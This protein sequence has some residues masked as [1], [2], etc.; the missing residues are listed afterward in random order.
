[1][2]N[3]GWGNKLV[4]SNKGWGNK[5]EV[6]L[7]V[8]IKRC[9]VTDKWKDAITPTFA[10]CAGSE[11]K[12]QEGRMVGGR[13]YG[14]KNARR[15]EKEF[16]RLVHSQSQKPPKWQ[17]WATKSNRVSRRL[18]FSSF[19]VPRVCVHWPCVRGGR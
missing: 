9:C 4:M 17:K 10:V 12:G 18:C 1:M 19:L 5:L 16:S 8:E 14:E 6:E 2:L 3:K 15:R 7:P 13:I 11:E